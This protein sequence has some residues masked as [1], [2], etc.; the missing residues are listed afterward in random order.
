MVRHHRDVSS[1]DYIQ[2]RGWSLVPGHV[3]RSFDWKG[4]GMD[5]RRKGRRFGATTTT[6]STVIPHT[7][8]DITYHV[9]LIRSLLD[10]VH[11]KHRHPTSTAKHDGHVPLRIC[12]IDYIFLG[13]R[14][15]IWHIIDGSTGY[16]T[17]NAGATS[18]A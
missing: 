3:C 10:E 6:K 2:R 11:H 18:R 16:Q 8:V 5:W 12:G 14:L 15:Q 7:L 13:Y 1:D 17:T 4:L 9:S